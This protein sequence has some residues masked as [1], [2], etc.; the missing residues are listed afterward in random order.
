MDDSVE[1]FAQSMGGVVAVLATLQNPKQVKHLV[2]TVTSGGIDTS[3]LGAVDWRQEHRATDPHAPDWFE[4]DHSELTDRLRE[5]SCPVLL[6]W[7]DTDPISPVAVG[8]RLAELFPN[9][10]LAII[11]GGKHNLASECVDHILPY[12]DR[13]LKKP[14]NV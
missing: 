13:H 2:L 11:P 8:R 6:L 5:I 12:V 9:A 7:G 3:A 1:L 4:K 10:E 14:V